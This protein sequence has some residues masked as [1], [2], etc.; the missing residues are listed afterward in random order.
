[1]VIETFPRAKKKSRIRG[2]TIEVLRRIIPMAQSKRRTR[3]S[4]SPIGDG[5]A[6]RRSAV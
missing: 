4:R 1:M 5:K 2:V 3:R 6:G